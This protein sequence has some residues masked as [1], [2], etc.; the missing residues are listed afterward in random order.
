M[1][2]PSDDSFPQSVVHAAHTTGQ[3]QQPWPLRGVCDV[4][5]GRLPSRRG[6]PDLYTGDATVS[7]KVGG[8]ETEGAFE[9][10]EV[11]APRGS[12]APPHSEPWSKAF[13]VLSGRMTV[14]VDGEQYDLGPGASITIPPGAPNTFE[15]TTPTVQ[16]LTF[17][18]TDAMGKF[19]VDIDN[20]IARGQPLDEIM[21][22]LMEI[23]ARHGVLI[24]AP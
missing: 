14:T 7:V 9:L 17:A 11:A 4:E 22:D 2:R 20:I 3:G 5:Q 19:F 8:A 13:Y 18:L 21:P 24:V 15:A 16:F 12:A 1:D 23:T 6:G 10:F